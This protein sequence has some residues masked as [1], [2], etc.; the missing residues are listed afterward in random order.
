MKQLADLGTV[1]AYLGFII[2]AYGTLKYGNDI[3]RGTVGQ[4]SVFIGAA[5]CTG[6]TGATL[7][8][9]QKAQPKPKPKPAA[10]GPITPAK[11]GITPAK[12]KPK[13]AATGPRK[14]G[15][16][17]TDLRKRCNDLDGTFRCDTRG[18]KCYQPIRPSNINVVRYNN[19]Y[20]SVKR[21]YL[22]K[23]T[24]SLK[25][26]AAQCGYTVQQLQ[27]NTAL[28]CGNQFHLTQ[29]RYHNAIKDADKQCQIKF[30]GIDAVRAASRIVPRSNAD[31]STGYT[32]AV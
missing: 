8:A 13:P 15:I 11:R 31:P 26:I 9:C 7:T 29:F 24:Q 6:L 30:L 23:M 3:L 16:T 28:S 20:K 10:T 27:N 12:P 22:S 25:N 5:G 14:V 2:L 19:C 18:C 17:P 32:Y 21:Y 1:L 4:D